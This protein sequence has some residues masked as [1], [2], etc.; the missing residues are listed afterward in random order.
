[1]KQI[2][3][4]IVLLLLVATGCGRRGGDSQA[5]GREVFTPAYAAGFDIAEAG[6]GGST[7]ITVRNP[8]QGASDVSSRLMVLRGDDRVP[9]GF[10]GQ[11]LRGNARRV[12]VTSSTHVAMLDALGAVNTIVG[13]SGLDYISNEAVRRGRD[14]IADI[15]YEGHFNYE[16]LVGARP[17][18]VLLYGVNGASS[19]EN[20]LKELGIPY[21]YVGDY[22]EESPLGK[23][24]WLVALGEV[25]GRRAEAERCFAPLSERY[26]AL[27]E[28]VSRFA[29][30]K[31]KVMLNAPYGDSWFMPSTESYVARL[32]ADAG[33]DY[34]YKENTGNASRPVDLEEAYLLASQ[35]DCWLNA[36]GGDT[37]TVEQLR[38]LTP[39]FADVPAV[40]QDRVY[41]N[42]LRST[43][44]GGNDFYESGIVHP[45]LILRDL[46]KIFYP[47][48]VSEGFEY[49]RRLE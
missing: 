27:K 38:T 41:N 18:L 8:W 9:E 3:C 6:D 13:V 24:E 43:P 22:V 45:D 49:Y 14:T 25:V 47:D 15:G 37:R 34:I 1:M 33:G 11:V 5:V 2:I 46:V 12:V 20:K 4:T 42:N 35:A 48:S 21:M 31:P 30:A 36:G 40:R 39:K 7:V 23:A 17:D 10:D 28:R 26:N 32:I 44:A 29:G 19:M 16:A